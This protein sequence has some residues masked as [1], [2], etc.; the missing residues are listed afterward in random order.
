MFENLLIDSA[1]IVVIFTI[2]LF[3][4]FQVQYSTST[5]YVY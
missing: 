4:S 1:R 5:V 2:L 3:I